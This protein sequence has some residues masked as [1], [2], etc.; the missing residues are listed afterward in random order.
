M[1]YITELKGM[2]GISFCFDDEQL[3]DR[4]L[5]CKDRLEAGSA[6]DLKADTILL[7]SFHS[8]AIEGARTMIENVKRFLHTPESK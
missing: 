8:A 1:Q 6:Y 4:F 3:K 7:D 2:N 5:H